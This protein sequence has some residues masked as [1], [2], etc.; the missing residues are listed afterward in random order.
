MYRVK[1]QLLNKH[2]IQFGGDAHMCGVGCNLKYITSSG[3]QSK[4]FESH[5]NIRKETELQFL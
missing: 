5:F 2:L 4:S 3:S 1:D